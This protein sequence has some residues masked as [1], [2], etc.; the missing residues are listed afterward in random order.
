MIALMLRFCTLASLPFAALLVPTGFRWLLRPCK[1][2]YLLSGRPFWSLAPL[3]TTLPELLCLPRQA[4]SSKVPCA[5][6]AA[7]SVFTGIAPEP[8]GRTWSQRS[9][10][11]KGQ[12]LAQRRYSLLSAAVAALTFE[13]PTVRCLPTSGNVKAKINC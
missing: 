7:E 13:G 2:S 1:Q 10:S 9:V 8:G 6:F 3:R 4:N 5:A 11:K 12:Y